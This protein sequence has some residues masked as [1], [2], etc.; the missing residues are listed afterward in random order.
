MPLRDRIAQNHL[1]ADFVAAQGYVFSKI[2]KLRVL[3][4]CCMDIWSGVGNGLPV[5]LGVKNQIKPERR[6]LGAARLSGHASTV[7]MPG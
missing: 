7:G 3:L 2:A 4:N 6:T 5:T 1:P